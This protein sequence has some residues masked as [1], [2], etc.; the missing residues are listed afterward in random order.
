MSKLNDFR[1]EK[2]M[3]FNKAKEALNRIMEVYPTAEAVYEDAIIAIVGTEGLQLLRENRLIESCAVLY[4][5]K[6][7]AV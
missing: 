3:N 1:K 7:Y 5:R 2:E 4:G 6:L